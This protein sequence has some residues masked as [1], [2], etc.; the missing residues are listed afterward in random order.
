MNARTLVLTPWYLPYRVVCWEDAITLVYLDK[1]EVV[2]SYSQ[3]VRSPSVTLPLPAVIRMK[4]RVSTHRYRIR[5]SRVN[6]FMRDE[7]RCMYCGKECAQRELTF[8]HVIPRSQG[9][10][11]EWANILSACNRC[12]TKK[13]NRTPAQADMAPIRRPFKPDTL[14]MRP[15][16]LDLGRI[17]EEWRDFCIGTEASWA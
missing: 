8:D 2:V 13:G 6:V 9:G 4:K 11:T 1:V 14:P 15:Q 16:R 7:F 5:F 10:R 12:N 17:P 3:V